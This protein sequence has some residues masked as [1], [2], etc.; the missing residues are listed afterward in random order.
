MELAD[1]YNELEKKYDL[2]RQKLKENDMD[3]P[4]GNRR[5]PKKD[6]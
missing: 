1:R 3:E 5:V 4:S 2:I 6:E